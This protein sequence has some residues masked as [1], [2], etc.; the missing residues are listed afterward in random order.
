MEVGKT[1]KLIQGPMTN[2]CLR[3][4][5]SKISLIFLIYCLQIQ[6]NKRDLSPWVV[7]QS[8]LKLY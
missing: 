2:V 5:T 7:G 8:L 6:Q 1:E 4:C 3:E